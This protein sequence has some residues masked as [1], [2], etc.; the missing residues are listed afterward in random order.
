[1]TSISDFMQQDHRHCDDLFV[2]VENSAQ[3]GDWAAAAEQ[4]QSYRRRIER[5]IEMEEAVLF[6]AFEAA[7]GNTAG[8]TEMMRSEHEQMRSVLGVLDD[9]I[10]SQDQQSF[11]GLTEALM[12][13]TQQHNMKEEQILYPMTD[14]ALKDTQTIILEMQALGAE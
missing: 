5:H 11:L 1:M 8:P 12:L 9:C 6:P 2:E 4:W 3:N 13:L 14:Q 7:T 10:A